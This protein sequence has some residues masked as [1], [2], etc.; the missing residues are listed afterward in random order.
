[1]NGL[2]KQTGG[3]LKKKDLKYNKRGKIVS[4]KL[5]AMAIQRGGVQKAGTKNVQHVQHVQYIPDNK[6]Y[7]IKNYPNINQHIAFDILDDSDNNHIFFKKNY[8]GETST[9]D[10]KAC[11]YFKEEPKNSNK[12]RGILKD[13]KILILDSDDNSKSNPN[14]RQWCCHLDDR[15]NTHIIQDIPNNRLNGMRII[16]IA[17]ARTMPQVFNGT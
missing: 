8:Y 13:L 9:G 16:P 4:K 17:V 10:F 15:N 14:S 1:M 5:S 12:M 2:A 7:Y 3:G 6:I 11:I